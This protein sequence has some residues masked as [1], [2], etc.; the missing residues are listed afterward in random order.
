MTMP[1]RPGTYGQQVYGPPSSRPRPFPA[2]H[3][4]P[5]PL[6]PAPARPAVTFLTAAEIAAALRVSKM[7][8]Y[9]LIHEGALA[10]IRVGRSFRV[11][12]RSFDEYMRD[13]EGADIQEYGS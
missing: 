13:V 12:Q 4:V 5:R 11:P 9:R 8:V 1:P 3:H 6:P 7:T 10:S 2:T